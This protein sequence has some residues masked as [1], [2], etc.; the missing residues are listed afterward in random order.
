MH[1]KYW[2]S[3]IATTLV[4]FLAAFSFGAEEIVTGEVTDVVQAVDQNGA[5]YTR[6]IVNFERKLEGQEYT[7]G[8]PVMGFGA[9]AEPAAALSVGDTL[10][11][12][13]S[14]RI[15]QDRESFTIIQL[16]E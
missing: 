10:K 11:A 1:K 8:L 15:Y 7:V 9:Q 4:L 5:A 3:I 16:L 2:I 14:K 12:I 13:C 6:L